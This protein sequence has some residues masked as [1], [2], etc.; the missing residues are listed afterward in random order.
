[1][2]LLCPLTSVF[3]LSNTVFARPPISLLQ[4]GT[5][6][7]VFH[8]RRCRRERS[9]AC[10]PVPARPRRSAKAPLRS[11][12]NAKRTP[13][14]TKEPEMERRSPPLILLL[15]AVSWF[16][17]VL[18]A[19]APSLIRPWSPSDHRRLSRRS[20]PL[21]LGV[22]QLRRTF[23]SFN[24]SLPG[25]SCPPQP[26]PSLVKHTHHPSELS[27]SGEPASSPA[28]GGGHDLSCTFSQ[29]SLSR[30]CVS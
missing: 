10:V 11:Y 19:K 4:A 27:Y 5:L 17:T 13:M 21:F 12:P 6:V 29:S 9:G 26:S 15:R 24:E 7:P 14:P 28:H 18:G 23:S 3:F 1:M 2:E 22:L 16:P 8:H 20:Y 30:T 25:P